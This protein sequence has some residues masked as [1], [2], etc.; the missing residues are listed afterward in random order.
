MKR[1]DK[2]IQLHEF[3]DR[4]TPKIPGFRLKFYI[5]DLVVVYNYFKKAESRNDL[6]I[7]I[8]MSKSQYFTLKK[9]N[10]HEFRLYE[11]PI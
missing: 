9:T 5:F 1:L 8:Y 7:K 6:D 3:H 10:W 2:V 4:F 11:L